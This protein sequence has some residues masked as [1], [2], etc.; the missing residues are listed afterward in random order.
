MA[1][2]EYVGA[3][4]V[5]IFVGEW[6]STMQTT[7]EPL[8]IVTVANVGSYTSKKFVPVNIPITDT[9]Y[10]ALSGSV[11]GQINNLISR[12]TN[13]ESDI[14]SLQ[15]SDVAINNDITVLKNAENHDN[16]RVVTIA[17]SYGSHP[18][19]T[20]S[21]TGRLSAIVSGIAYQYNIQQNGIG[22][23]RQSGGYNAYTL[24]QAEKSNITDI[25]TITDVV[26]CL[27]M[28]DCDETLSNVRTNALALF[29]Q[30][31][32]DM[33]NAKIW[34]GYPELGTHL[35]DD[36][37]SNITLIIGA[38]EGIAAR[39]NY[40][41][42]MSGLENIMHD[43][44]FQ[45]AD[46][47]HPNATG[48]LEI[49]RGIAACM[50]GGS[51][52]YFLS[53]NRQAHWGDGDVSACRVLIDGD[54]TRIY[55]EAINKSSAVALTASNWVTVATLDSCRIMNRSN[56][57][58]VINLRD[59]DSTDLIPA[60][61]KTEGNEVKVLLMQGNHT[62]RYRMPNITIIMPTLES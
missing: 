30:I 14:I 31:H 19:T 60:E 24:Y 28:N 3:R 7:Y 41:K 8:S 32:A 57:S 10:W 56:A 16:R 51:Y 27:G 2:R 6:D 29:N 47:A 13:A 17:D 42:W 58:V 48:S 35:N 44:A 15:N 18:D 9:D 53:T 23:Y 5:P 39:C 45:E 22:Y 11:N 37:L 55:L 49:V 20:N 12:M 21:W 46:G 34:V 52:K 38:V 4:Y 43:T 25:S 1:V 36:Q 62:I 50:N 54:I 61:V 40:C 33:P 59:V 26:V